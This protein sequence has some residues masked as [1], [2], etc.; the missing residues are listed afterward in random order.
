MVGALIYG[1][2]GCRFCSQSGHIP[3]L[4]VQ[5]LVGVRTKGN[6]SMFFSLSLMSSGEDKKNLTDHLKEKRLGMGMGM[7]RGKRRIKQ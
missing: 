7:V 4:Q 6:L 1:L 3:G 5:S 2:K